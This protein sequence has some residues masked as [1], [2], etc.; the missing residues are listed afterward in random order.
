MSKIEFYTSKNGW[1][2][3]T[4]KAV[5]GFMGRVITCKGCGYQAKTLMPAI[6]SKQYWDS[7]H[8]KE[9]CDNRKAFD[10]LMGNPMDTL[11]G[12]GIR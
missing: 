11:A 9:F 6:Y 5:D 7:I 1:V 2:K 4:S 8:T 3:S 10:N 12:I